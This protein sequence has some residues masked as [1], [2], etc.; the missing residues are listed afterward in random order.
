VH[1]NGTGLTIRVSVSSNGDQLEPFVYSE[2]ATT[3]LDGVDHVDISGNGRVVVFE[4]HANG[5]VDEDYNNNVDIF[6]HEIESGLTQRV[7]V[8]TGGGDADRPEDRE[9]GTNGQCF[10]F[11]LTRRACRA[12]AASSPSFLAPRASTREIGSTL[13]DG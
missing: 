5:L 4:S 7:S 9:C 2:S 8:A 3:Y 1:D 13:W 6:A 11:I 10:T 12:T